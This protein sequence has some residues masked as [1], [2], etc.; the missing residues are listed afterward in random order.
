MPEVVF[1]DAVGTLFGIRGTVGAIYAEAAARFGVT[2][3]PQALDRA[4]YAS[5]EAAPPAAFPGVKSADLPRLEHD[6]WRAV[7]QGSLERVG[8]PVDPGFPE[9]E[10]YFG[11]M[12]ELFGTAAPWSLYEETIEVLSQWR[13]RGIRLGLISNFD[14]RLYRV[15]TALGLD[16]FFGPEQ[17]TLSTV[18][19]AAK[20][21]RR[22]FEMALAQQGVTDAGKA[23]HIGD[24][25][26][27]D[28][29]GAVQAGLQGLWLNREGAQPTIPDGIRSLRDSLGR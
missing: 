11:Q 5:F 1:F 10:V 25:L 24:S 15:L 17:V 9:F 23:L 2:V 22:V 19:G 28:Y 7:V 8:I 21:D 6:W 13:D 26:R 27:Q 20:P 4:F 3:D 18:V 12:Y 29:Q 14:T 16:P